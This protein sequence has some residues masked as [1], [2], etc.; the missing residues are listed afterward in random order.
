MYILGKEETA[1]SVCSAH[2]VE[3]WIVDAANIEMCV[4]NTGVRRTSLCEQVP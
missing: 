4:S 2:S 1:F 3:C